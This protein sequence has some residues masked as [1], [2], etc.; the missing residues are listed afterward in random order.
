MSPVWARAAAIVAPG[1]Q[2]WDESR[3]VLTGERLYAPAQLAPFQPRTL[4]ANEARRMTPTIRLAL[5]VAEALADSCS[6]DAAGLWS[7][8]A[9]PTGDL[10]IADRICRGLALPDR[11]VSPTLFHNSV[12]NAPAGYWA[13]GSRC[14][15]GST[16]LAAGEGTFAA[17]LLEAA[18]TVVA[19]GRRVLLVVY[20]S[21]P[22]AAFSE[23]LGVTAPVGLGLLLE[24]PGS[25]EGH[26]TLRF[27]L[28]Q[29]GAETRLEDPGLESLRRG[30]PAARGLPLL[31][32]I[33]RAGAAGAV[34]LPYR[35]DLSLVAELAPP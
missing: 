20:E 30:N 1:L 17:A 19:E 9:S 34:V 10:D 12:Y 6:D 7:V 5:E 23:A 25:R 22:P 32:L 29:G 24:P 8:F 31:A 35:G 16:S 3:A 2:G 27:S 33:A 4:S 28:S 21:S 26:G 14:T 13:I 11:P 15:G 18:V